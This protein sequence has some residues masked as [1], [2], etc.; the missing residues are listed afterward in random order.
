M[1]PSRPTPRASR[2]SATPD[3]H[4]CWSALVCP[5][6][7]AGMPWPYPS[8][9][10]P[11]HADKPFDKAC[12]GPIWIAQAKTSCSPAIRPPGARSR[13]AR[14]WPWPCVSHLSRGPFFSLDAASCM[15]SCRSSGSINFQV[16]TH[17]ARRMRPVLTHLRTASLERKAGDFLWLYQ[18]VSSAPL[19]VCHR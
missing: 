17:R 19:A 10:A 4:N 7:F 16:R 9:R 6:L 18:R 1:I 11:S 2:S 3:V 12:C 5:A 13:A 14:F 8:L 15:A